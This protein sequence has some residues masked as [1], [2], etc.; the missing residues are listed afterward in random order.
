MHHVLSVEQLYNREI[1]TYT[2]LM[3][4]KSEVGPF[5]T[6]PSYI[7][8]AQFLQ[9]FGFGENGFV[10]QGRGFYNKFL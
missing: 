7:P 8:G 9:A 10:G 2:F 4:G 6:D 5:A 1:Q 3:F